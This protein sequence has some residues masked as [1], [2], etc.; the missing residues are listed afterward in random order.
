M[1]YQCKAKVKYVTL[2]YRSIMLEVIHGLEGGTLLL[3]HKII[4]ITDKLVKVIEYST[5]L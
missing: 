5:E 3:S 2:E 1:S 4:A